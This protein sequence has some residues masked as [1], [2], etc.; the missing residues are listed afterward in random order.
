M[1]AVAALF[2]LTLQSGCSK[3]IETLPTTVPPTLPDVPDAYEGRC[4]FPTQLSDSNSGNVKVHRLSQKSCADR[5]DDFRDWYVEEVK[6]PLERPQ[7]RT[8]Q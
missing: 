2:L 7:L 3:S 5:F 1:T 8:K 6:K 4:P